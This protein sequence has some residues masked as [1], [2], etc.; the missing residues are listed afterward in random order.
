MVKFS[1]I[2]PV[3]NESDNIENLILEIFNS[4]TIYE[5]F[6]LIIVDDGS[7]DNS[8]IVIKCILQTYIS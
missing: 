5:N 3:F 8:L 1:I 4:L 2:I 7:K 6:E